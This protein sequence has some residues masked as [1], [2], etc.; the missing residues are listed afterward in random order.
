MRS[1]WVIYQLAEQAR[2]ILYGGRRETL[3]RAAPSGGL[4]RINKFY[5]LHLI[6][7]TGKLYF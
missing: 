6:R 5:I 2:L 1:R 3:A 4:I 7:F